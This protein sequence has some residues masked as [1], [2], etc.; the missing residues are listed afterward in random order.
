M[1]GEGAPKAGSRFAGFDEL[2]KALA[3]SALAQRIRRPIVVVLPSRSAARN[4]LDNFCFFAGGRSGKHAHYLPCVDFDFYRGLLPNPET[5]FERNVS[6][7]HAMTDPEGRVF[8]TTVRS[9]LQKV[10]PREEFRRSVVTLRSNE[11]L[12]RDK[13]IL[14]LH[15]AGYQNQPSAY[16]PG[17]FAIRG[18]VI[19]IFCPLYPK[20]F[21][22]EFFGDLVEEIRFFD[23][24]SQLSAEKVETALVVPVGQTLLPHGEAFQDASLRIK[25]RL[26]NLGVAKH[27]REEILEKIANHQSFPELGL[28]FP[29]LSKGSA[30]PLEYFPKDTFLL[31]DGFAQS[32]S[33]AEDTEIPALDK[34]YELYEKEPIP[35]AKKNELFVTLAEY[36]ALIAE[37]SNAS[38]E[39]FAS[40]HASEIPIKRSEARLQ[41]SNPGKGSQALL[42]GASQKI[43]E[44]MDLGYRVNLVCHTRTH[45]ERFQMLIEPY[46]I[47]CTHHLSEE[48]PLDEMLEEDFGDVHLWQGFV[49][50]SQVYPELKLVVLSEEEVFGQKKRPAKAASWT[51]KADPARLLQSFR[52]L[53]TG[54]LVV[55]KEHGIGKYMG[56][57][58]ML[59]QEVPNDFVVLEYKDGDKLYVP[60]YRLNVLQKYVGGE[61]AGS[62][63]VDKLGGERWTKAKRKAQKA[64]ALLAAEFLKMQAKRRLIPAHAFPP[65]GKE[66]AQFEMEFAFDETPDQMKAINDVMADLGK[67][68]PMD[69]LICGDVGYGK[70]EVAMRATFRAINDGKQVAILVPTTVLAF[71]HFENFKKRFLPSG[72]K[73]EM[74]S[75]LRTNSET[76][77]TL[78]HL[79]EGSIDIIIGTHRILSTDVEFKALGLVIVDEEHRFG[80]IHKERLKKI[81]ESVHYLTMTATPIPRTLNM[82]MSGIKDISII[83]TPPPDRLSVRTFVARRTDELIA[84]AVSNELARDGQ[85]FFVHNRIETQAKVAQELQKLL[86]RVRIEVVHGQMDA[87]V[88]EKRMLAFYQ[89]DAKILL[90]TAIIESGLDI[91]RA[92]TILIDRADHFGLAQL[93]QLRGRVGRSER[94]AYCYLLVHDEAQI[95]E[96]AKERLQVL[97]RYTDLGAGFQV[98]SHDLELRGAG[99]LLGSDQS[100]YLT[101][102]GVDYYFELLEDSMRELRG[103]ERRIEVEPEINL[104]IPAFFPEY[105]IPDITER[106]NLYRRLSSVEQEGQVAETEREVRDRFGPPPEEVANLLGLMRIKLYLK[107]LHVVRMGVGPKRT[108]LQFASTTPVTP[109]SIVKLVSD[110]SKK[111]SVTPDQKL[112]F[113]AADTSWSSQLREIQRVCGLLGFDFG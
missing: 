69:R 55:H 36:K 41:S 24:Q 100:G 42:F 52:D 51:S 1:E 66:Y 54:D 82:A 40:G 45:A 12:D 99:D 83:T 106:I 63:S 48:A 84:E 74:I 19:D 108:S 15:E 91:S 95:T 79:K 29:L 23:P 78:Q 62:L 37:R 76:K 68:H 64:V 26:D 49:S 93:Y 67:S 109:E 80:V 50:H 70:T 34:N 90:S 58:S 87:D 47:S 102:I 110:K 11:E 73:V 22:L 28:L 57:K 86:P 33:I 46:D 16:D 43:K 65:T 61:G 85:V 2:S 56:L 107:R 94:R 112:V 10:V 39:T 104:R 97:Q 5:L 21:R 35:I 103:Q 14:S 7:Y 17:V 3:V 18:G 4:A 101:A 111:F 96:D 32:A 92:N 44:W 81:S 77:L 6:L 38:F 13:F 31:W 71:Q 53:K 113:E 72:A 25:E 105:Y 30:S 98:A 8:F 9:V 88:L 27:R 59:V 89:G 20:P 60:I 75:R